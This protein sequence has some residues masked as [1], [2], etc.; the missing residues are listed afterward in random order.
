MG[1]CCKY[2]MQQKPGAFIMALKEGEDCLKL[3]RGTGD[4]SKKEGSRRYDPVTSL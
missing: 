4:Q 3:V 1:V 2:I